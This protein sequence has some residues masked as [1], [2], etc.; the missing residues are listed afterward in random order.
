MKGR[1][2]TACL[3]IGC[4]VPCVLG[5]GDACKSDGTHIVRDTDRLKSHFKEELHPTAMVYLPTCH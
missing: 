1:K 3:E 2:G 4:D 5:V